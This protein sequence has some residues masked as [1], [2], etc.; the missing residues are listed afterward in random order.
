[1][2]PQKKRIHLGKKNN[3]RHKLYGKKS[4]YQLETLY[5]IKY[6]LPSNARDEKKKRNLNIQEG[7]QRPKLRGT[8]NHDKHET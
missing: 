2:S 5:T 6:S 7:L 3:Y 1:M 8:T 4:F